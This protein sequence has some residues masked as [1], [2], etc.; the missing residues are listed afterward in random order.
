[1]LPLNDTLA[2]K[3]STGSPVGTAETDSTAIHFDDFM[4]TCSE[5]FH[6]ALPPASSR[7]RPASATSLL[8]GLCLDRALGRTGR[9]L[10]RRGG[11]LVL[12][13]RVPSATWVDAVGDAV[14]SMARSGTSVVTATRPKT[15]STT[16]ETAGRLI[17]LGN[18]VVGIAPSPDC[19]ATTLTA[20]ADQEFVI[21][22]PDVAVMNEALRRWCRRRT[23]TNLEP[24]DLAGVDLNDL[25]AALRP[26][27]SSPQDCV[28]RIRRAARMRNPR[29]AGGE[30]PR[31]EALSG[32][33]EAHAWALETVA[34][35]ERSRA[36]GTRP[37]L[38]SCVFFGPPG[39]GKTI[40]AHSIASTAGVP[41]VATS[42][43]EW[44][45]QSP[46]YLDSI[47][48]AF[49]SFFQQLQH[50]AASTG[51]GAVIGFMDEL[52]AIPDRAQMSGGRSDWWTPVVTGLLLQI[53][54][55]RRTA[56]SVILLGATNHVSRI[57]AA[58]LRPGR[59]DRTIEI[60]PP[61]E[62]GRAGILR[63]HLGQDLSDTDLTQ[64]ARLCP[65]ATGAV[66]EGWV[67]AARRRAR[68]EH[69][70]I[71]L[72]DLLHEVAPPDSR[73]TDEL[74]CVALH[75]AAHA[76]L[77]LRLGLEVAHVT[78]QASGVA[79]GHT[80]IASRNF[81]PGR[82]LLEAQAVATLAGRAA[83]QTLGAQGANAGAVADL[84]EATKLIA[85]IHASLGLGSTLTH[86][87]AFDE[88]GTLLRFDAKLAMIV[89]D[90]LQRLLA[91]A[92]TLVRTHESAIRAVAAAL[93]SR[94]TLGGDE[95]TQI[96][97]GH[98]PAIRSWLKAAGYL[99][100]GASST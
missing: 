20:A 2:A 84:Q 24:N 94:R 64:I 67:K 66:L 52:D 23:A 87:I 26:G 70:P 88:A 73:T 80:R 17:A 15:S 40:L 89:E 91:L 4:D 63:T 54:Q 58:L 27:S 48:K 25:A 43:S 86:R 8:V 9:R 74:R 53:D 41:I 81:M 14:R 11:P 90:E 76:V 82:A 51:S 55:T 50:Q 62:R 49:T 3:T 44:F 32:Y 71:D 65:N 12:I 72:Q 1:M 39:T 13:I 97:E 56:P 68:A 93:M 57:D 69:R 19:L 92:V 6:D 29:R 28:D 16:D 46:G 83:D 59:F 7:R 61:D 75:E 22:L 98:P 47:V 5:T 77:A 85:G 79:E 37:E 33:G 38:G 45:A 95:V 31:L 36:T 34:E 96:L 18:L 42:V 60:S 21:S 30:V 99:D 10:L 35:I 100:K 78:I